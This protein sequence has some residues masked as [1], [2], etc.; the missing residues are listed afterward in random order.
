MAGVWWCGMSYLQLFMIATAGGV[1]LYLMTR[2][3]ESHSGMVEG[4]ED[5]GDIFSF[6]NIGAG[7]NAFTTS[8]AGIELIKRFEG[9]KP[10]IYDANPPT[11]DWTIGYGHKIKPGEKFTT[12]T[13]DQA[14]KLLIKD[15]GFAEERVRSHINFPLKQ[16][17][18][19]ALVSLAFNLTW[20]SWKAAAA[21][22]NKGESVES[23]LN[24]YTYAAG[25]QLAGLVKRRGLEVALYKTGVLA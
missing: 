10:T 4:P 7:V 6:F 12:V 25:K 14:T 1:L 16:H 17:Q 22:L 2:D 5:E 21:R 20:R 11:G 8:F 18:F 19:D 3:G 13:T 23:V 24:R 15:I 9:F